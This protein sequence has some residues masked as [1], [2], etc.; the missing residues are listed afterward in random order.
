MKGGD[1]HLS[2]VGA[3]QKVM[4]HH[5]TYISGHA[6]L[7]AIFSNVTGEHSEYLQAVV[8]VLLQPQKRILFGR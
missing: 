6:Q 2:A 1:N 5:L 8:F 7:G 3:G 4:A